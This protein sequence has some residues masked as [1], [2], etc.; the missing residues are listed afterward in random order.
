[1]KIGCDRLKTYIANIEQPLRK[2]RDIAKSS[3]LE[4]GILKTKLNS[5]EGRNEEK[6]KKELSNETN[7]KEVGMQ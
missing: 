6:R 1:M 2:M 3:I 7:R 4:Y 5:K